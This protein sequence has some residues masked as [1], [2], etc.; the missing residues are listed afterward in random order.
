MDEMDRLFRQSDFSAENE[1][2]GKRIWNR[3]T[4]YNA[5]TVPM[6]VTI[7]EITKETIQKAMKCKDAGELI[8][9]AKTGGVELTKE[10]A[11]AYMAELDDFELDDWRLKMV[12]GGACWDACGTARKS[13]RP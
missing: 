5:E 4:H 7:N 8:A 9:L 12:A 1:E 6:P 13:D 3:L 2:L 10:E 11:E